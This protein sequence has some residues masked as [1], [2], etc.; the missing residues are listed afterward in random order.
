MITFRPQIHRLPHLDV[1]RE[2]RE[3]IDTPAEHQASCKG[4][5]CDCKG[6]VEGVIRELGRPE[7][8][9]KWVTARDY[10]VVQPERLLEGVRTVF[11]AVDGALPGDILLILLKGKPRH[12]A[13]VTEADIETGKPTRIVHTYATGPRRVREVPLGSM[14]ESVHSIWTW[15]D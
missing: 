14:V 9:L 8:R 13:I 5:G 11:N 6:L 3:W 2:A 4:V 1:V 7:I 12:M 15:R 10:K